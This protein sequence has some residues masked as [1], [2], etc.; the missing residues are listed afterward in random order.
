MELIFSHSFMQSKSS[1]KETKINS[2]NFCFLKKR[3]KKNNRGRVKNE[4]NNLDTTFLYGVV[5]VIVYLL[6]PQQVATGDSQVLFIIIST[7]SKWTSRYVSCVLN[8]NLKKFK[9]KVV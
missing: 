5:H 1:P 8:L 3:E 4:T 7:L 2:F 6:G 9:N